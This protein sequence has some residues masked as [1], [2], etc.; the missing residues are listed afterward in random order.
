MITEFDDIY[1]AGKWV[2][3]DSVARTQIRNSF[4]EEVI[5]TAPL[6][7]GVDVDRAVRGARDAF[8]DPDGW[9]SWTPAQRATTLGRLAGAYNERAQDIAT[10]VSQQNGMPISTAKF[11]EGV[12][13]G[14]LMDYYG[15]LAV[16]TPLAH[17]RETPVGG[18]TLVTN[19]PIGVI[20]AI[21]PWNFPQLLSAFKYSAALAAGCT[22]V[23]KPSPQT[24]L[25]AMIF[26]EIVE[27]AGLPPGVINVIAGAVE[28][29]EDK[30][31]FTGSDSVGRK[32][33]ERCGAQLTPVTLELGGKSAAI[34][35]DDADLDKLADD[36]VA[37]TFLN[38]GQT[39]YACTR[40]LA[41][42]NMFE[43]VVEFF[44]TLAKSLT[45]GDPLDPDTQIGPL[46]SAE[47][48][49]S[50]ER[51]ITQGVAEGGVITTGG[52]RPRRF[53]RGYFIEPTVFTGLSLD[54][55]VAQE[56]IFGP[57]LTI[58]P[59]VTEDDA[60]RIANDSRYGLAGTVW[61]ADS[62]RAVGVAQ[63]IHTGTVG[64]NHYLPDISSPYG[65]VKD[66]GLGRELGPEGLAAYQDTKSIYLS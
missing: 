35:L 50:V 55:A 27:Q 49:T 20:A 19:S 41:P 10:A 48:R 63:R 54:S 39:C 42:A 36:I 16:A 56:E 38:N 64:I 30:V 66:S 15:Q 14:L 5:A 47:Q 37:A 2:R 45:V 44:T 46:V 65:G 4:D 9:S 51:Y 25:D 6:A 1:V 52:G 26:A 33:A 29:G 23:I 34:I 11:M 32:I 31:S 40:I 22:I 18:R 59:Y 53:D 28:A 60:V 43:T 24:V 12:V 13:P 62:A 7:N 57:V 58:I 17:T 8:D 3:A 61:S 21:T